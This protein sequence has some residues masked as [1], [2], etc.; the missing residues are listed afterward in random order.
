MYFPGGGRALLQCWR[1][2]WLIFAAAFFFIG[3]VVDDKIGSSGTWLDDVS[4]WQFC[5]ISRLPGLRS[6]Q[7]FNSIKNEYKLWSSNMVIFSK[8][9]TIPTSC[10]QYVHPWTD[11]CSSATTVLGVHALQES[12]RI[13][14]TVYMVSTDLLVLMFAYLIYVVL[15]I[16]TSRWR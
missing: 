2:S 11:S 10:T 4:P 9:Q 8:F 3:I 15:N 7:W 14:V 16:N 5:N 12:F 1:Q 13:Y 6:L